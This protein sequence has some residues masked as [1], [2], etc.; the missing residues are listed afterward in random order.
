MTLN[1]FYAICYKCVDKLRNLCP[2][3]TG[4]LA[5]NGITFKFVNERKFT[6]YVNEK[7]A[8]YMVYTNEPW[9]SAYW[10]G[11]KNPNEGWWNNAVGVLVDLIC[12]ELKGRVKE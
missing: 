4:N 11:K 8:P 9:V 2:Y 6:I 12:N 5:G 10:R 3:D 7:V 1:D